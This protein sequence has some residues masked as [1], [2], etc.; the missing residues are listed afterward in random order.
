VTPRRAQHVAGCATRTLASIAAIGALGLAIAAPAF[1]HG[2]GDVGGAGHF[3]GWHGFPNQHV[4]GRGHRWGQ[5]YG[6]AVVYW[7]GGEYEG[8]G[9]EH[10][11][12]DPEPCPPD[13]SWCQP[14]K[15]Q[16]APTRR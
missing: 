16:S 1:A 14:P 5:F 3:R 15:E 10:P 9:L 11:P 4:F 8:Y 7:P 12:L 6:G 13:R 2:I